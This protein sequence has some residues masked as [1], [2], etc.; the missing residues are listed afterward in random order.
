MYLSSNESFLYKGPNSKANKNK[1]KNKNKRAQQKKGQKGNQ[2]QA[3]MSQAKYV[4]PPPGF[5]SYV[6][7]QQANPFMSQNSNMGYGQNVGSNYG[8][9]QN[10]NGFGN[11]RW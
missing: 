1:N 2:S 6:P 4:P 8:N 10:G 5:G 3:P 9:L 11:G 7:A